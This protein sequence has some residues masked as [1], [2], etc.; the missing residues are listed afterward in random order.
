MSKFLDKKLSALVPYTP[1]E[2][3]KGLKNL[4]K[5]NTNESPFP[6]STL[7]K[8]ALH[9]CDFDDLRLYPD[10]E[11]DEFLSTLSKAYG[12]KRNM[13]TVGNGS[14]ELLAFAFN[15]LCENG[16]VF[17]DITYGFYPVFAGLYGVNAKIIPLR[18]DFTID[19][20]DYEGEK[21]TLFIANPNAPTGIALS[22]SSIEKLLL[23]DK[24]RLVVID[25]AYVDF[26][27]KSAVSLLKKHDNLL[28]IGTFSKSR[29][30]A[31][32][33]IGYAVSSSDIIADLNTVKFS[34]NPYNLNRMSLI[35][36]KCALDDEL[37]F[38]MCCN[39]IIKVRE[40]T[41]AALLEMGFQLTDSTANF[42]FAEPPEPLTGEGFYNKLRKSNILVR[43]FNVDRIKN[44]VRITIGT[45][46]EMQKFIDV[47][48]KMINSPQ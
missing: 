28:V 45:E 38:K 12:V 32:A 44:R 19:V 6:P 17:P 48:K 23:Q 26:G 10:P 33:R 20:N 40:K 24:Q 21:G 31:G 9:T 13:V 3:P 7:V 5:L 1:G 4:I 16:A 42:L 18:Q 47:T 29:N 15:A 35:A 8:K 34:F 30:L 22:L 11:C 37:Y 2:Q 25:E 14:D 43:H 36:G 39:E 46:E 27:A 41:G